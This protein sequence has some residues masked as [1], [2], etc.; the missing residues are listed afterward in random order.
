MSGTRRPSRGSNRHVQGRKMVLDVDLNQPA[1][2]E[3]R[4]TGTTTVSGRALPSL[5]YR[6]Q[7]AP[8][9]VEA[10]EDVV[11]ISSPTSFTEARNLSRRNNGATVVLDEDTSIRPSYPGVRPSRRDC[12]RERTSSQVVINCDDDD[13]CGVASTSKR[14]NV[15]ANVHSKSVDT[16]PK[17]VTF[18]CAVCMGTLTEPMSTIC[19]HIFCKT[20]IKT[21]IDVQKKC[22]TCRR[23]L[24]H[25]NIHRIYLPDASVR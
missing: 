20:C 16:A 12:K 5:S 13:D 23:K 4:E 19:G 18:T 3:S 10:I 24:T 15:G 9:D 21:S 8:I 11:V 1:S 2:L 25:S 6:R 7:V 17:E 22:P 14:R